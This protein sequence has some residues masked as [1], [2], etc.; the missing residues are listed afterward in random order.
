MWELWTGSLYFNKKKL[1]SSGT[2]TEAIF[3]N[4]TPWPNG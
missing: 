3:L 1:F 4:M 2:Y